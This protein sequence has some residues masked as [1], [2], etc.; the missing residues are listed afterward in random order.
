MGFPALSVDRV[1]SQSR[2]VMA[3]ST[4]RSTATSLK[5]SRASGTFFSTELCLLGSQE[6][7]YIVPE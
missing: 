7:F 2:S 1:G 5:K 4:W 6:E 3:T